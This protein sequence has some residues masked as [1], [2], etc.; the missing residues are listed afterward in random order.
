MEH[1]LSISRVGKDMGCHVTD[2]IG[3]NN[4]WVL[5]GICR[6]GTTNTSEGC[7]MP[8]VMQSHDVTIDWGGDVADR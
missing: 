4:P 2:Y 7:C 1:N 3:Y 8:K 5:D 6:V